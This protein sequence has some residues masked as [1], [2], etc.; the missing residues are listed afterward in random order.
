[1]KDK[2]SN[3]IVEKHSRHHLDKV[4]LVHFVQSKPGLRTNQHH[5]PFDIMH[6]EGPQITMVIFL[7]KMY[8]LSLIIRKEQ[9]KPILESFY[10][11]TGLYSSKMSKSRNTKKAKKL[12]YIKGN[13]KV[14]T[15]VM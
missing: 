11:I 15:I 1:M 4:N 9:T 2:D 3:F 6:S 13:E 10:K 14:M 5:V 12:F 7:P 8:N